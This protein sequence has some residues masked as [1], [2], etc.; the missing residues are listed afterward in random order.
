MFE[1]T[2]QKFVEDE[3]ST[4]AE[5]YQQLLE[6]QTSAN[7]TPEEQL[8]IQCLLASAD[9]DSFY[10]V[11]VKEAKKLILMKQA[12][13]VRDESAEAESKGGDEGDEEEEEKGAK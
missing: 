3:G 5:F 7:I 6:C 9:Y 8:F 13:R 10:S 12:G 1:E 4:N 11:M 2:L